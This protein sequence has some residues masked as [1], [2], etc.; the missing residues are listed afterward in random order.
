MPNGTKKQYM[1]NNTDPI[2]QEALSLLNQNKLSEARTL[3]DQYL[4]AHPND[5]E[6]WRLAAQVDL[7]Y[8][9]DADKAYD[10]LIEAL[11]LQPKNLWA[12]VLMGNLLLEN[13]KDSEGALEYFKKVL[14]FHPDNS[15][16]LA[17]IGAVMAKT[18]NYTDAFIFFSKSLKADPTYANAYY[19]MGLAYF[20]M[21]DYQ[22]AFEF[23][24]D[25]LHKEIGRAH[26]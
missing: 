17:N 5:S 15:V 3:L 8:Y 25:G 1:T 12:L 19:G 14:E 18:N 20:R 24:Q 4:K 6:G 13:K 16:A 2:M 10:E 21:E 23:A 11:R 22:K 26:V 7:N 9:K